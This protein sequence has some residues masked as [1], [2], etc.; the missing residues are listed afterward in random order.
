MN[1]GFTMQVSLEIDRIS[2]A[3]LW[4]Y[5]TVITL[6]GICFLINHVVFANHLLAFG[7]HQFQYAA[8]TQES[9]ISSIC[10]ISKHFFSQKCKA[11]KYIRYEK[12]IQFCAWEVLRDK[13]IQIKFVFDFENWLSSLQMSHF[14]G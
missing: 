14:F 3:I 5:T 8:N 2:Y 7:L 1:P 6:L 13:P 10:H 12:S 9:E 4:N 11:Y